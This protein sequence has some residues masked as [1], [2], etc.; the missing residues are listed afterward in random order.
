MRRWFKVFFDDEGNL[1]PHGLNDNASFISMPHKD[2]LIQVINLSSTIKAANL[3]TGQGDVHQCIGVTNPGDDFHT[4][5]T[6]GD[7]VHI[8]TGTTDIIS[9]LF[10]GIPDRDGNPGPPLLAISGTPPSPDGR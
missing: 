1:F 7:D 10:A 2:T 8:V 9:M 5:I 3:Y 4:Y 6:Y